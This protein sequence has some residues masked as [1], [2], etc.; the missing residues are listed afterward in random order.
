MMGVFVGLLM[1]CT[2]SNIDTIVN[3]TLPSKSHLVLP[4]IQIKGNALVAKRRGDTLVFTADRFKRPDALRLDQLLSNVPGFQVDP[5]GNIS[6]N[7]RPIKKL[8]LDGNDLTAENYHLISRNLRSLMVDSIQVIERYNEN[9][10][11][12]N[13]N[14]TND[15]AVNLVLK[16]AFY[17]KPSTNITTAY[18]PKRHGEFQTELIELRSK[19]KQMIVINA[20]NIGGHSFQHNQVQQL[21]SGNKQRTVYA[22]WPGLL[23]N[24]LVSTLEAKYINQNSDYGFSIAS[25]IKVNKFNQLRV[26]LDKSALLEANILSQLQLF[27]SV[28]G[29]SIV[30]F[31]KQIQKHI[32]NTT[33]VQ[34]YW[35]ADKGNQKR[36]VFEFEGYKQKS[37]TLVNEV[38]HFNKMFDLNAQSGLNANGF[39]FKIDYTRKT[40]SNHIWQ[41]ETI[42]NGSTNIY[43]VDI[44]R[45][46]VVQLDSVASTF[47]QFVKHG[48]VNGQTSLGHIRSTKRNTIRYWLK[49][50]ITQLHSSQNISSL[51]LSAFKSYLSAHLT[52]VVSRKINFDLQSMLGNV[53]MT[54]NRL[55]TSQSIYHIEQMFTWKPIATRQLSLNYGILKQEVDVTRFFAG[56]IYTTAAMQIAGPTTISFPVTLYSQLHFSLLDLYRG[57]N[58]Y[59]QLLISEIKRDYFI[60][61]NL[62][63]YYTNISQQIAER[64]SSV[65]FNFQLEKIIHPAR[66]K[67]RLLYTA[68]RLSG[69]SQL[70]AQRFIVGNTATRIGQN[71]STNWR[72]GYNFQVEYQFVQSVFSGFAS[73][74]LQ[75][76]R[77]DYKVIVELL[78]SRRLNAHLMLHHYTGRN[79]IP[80][81][82]FDFKMN[83]S[84]KSKYRF[85]LTGNNL[86]NRKLFFQQI[87]SANSI[88][89]NQ[90]Y[91]IGRRIV[92]GADIPL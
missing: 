9:R 45:N 68:M 14:G 26:N 2:S 4:E 90:Q 19:R 89:T 88:S 8:M 87:I 61:T 30:L 50:S 6:F 35:E 21:N 17:G 24:T 80:F 15:I 38:R 57:I 20:N 39:L 5:N 77:H 78:F 69:P 72:K 84:P 85:Y 36:T 64:Q 82:L 66:L 18:A 13:I 32:L 70:N 40:A 75:N 33:N 10:L 47:K 67:Y 43:Q 37:G 63:P 16:Q 3:D 58:L 55:G 29:N 62:H 71:I 52:R 51:Q 23:K 11:L 53:H 91:L 83:W 73:N 1:W 65:S 12:K 49:T 42:L 31:S 60:T 86:L 34:I 48:G 92:I 54:Y 59:T 7:G 46:D 74:A 76:S 56:T 25:S 28:N 44:S 27:S 79:I 81:E 22:S 41:W